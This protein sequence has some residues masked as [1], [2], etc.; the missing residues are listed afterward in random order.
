M[1]RGHSPSLHQYLAR[2]RYDSGIIAEPLRTS[3][4]SSIHLTSQVDS[5]PVTTVESWPWFAENGI[6]ETFQV[7]I[8]VVMLTR[9]LLL[10]MHQ[11]A[12][13]R[14]VFAGA[15]MITVGCILREVEFDPNGEFGWADRLLRGPGRIIAGVIAI[16]VSFLA[17]RGIL[18]RPW[19]LPRILLGT[20][21]GYS[22]IAGGLVVVVAGLYDRGVILDLPSNPWEEAFETIGYLL[23]A[24]SSFIPARTVEAAIARPLWSGSQ[25]PTVKISA[26]AASDTLG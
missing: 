4:E 23:V 5:D 1:A 11:T 13:L 24:V 6:L 18:R 16:P 7:F 15:A 3:A 10:A 17:I 19:A 25:A 26:K 22:C 14:A 2:L 8:L 12:V 9:Y 21:W 20:W